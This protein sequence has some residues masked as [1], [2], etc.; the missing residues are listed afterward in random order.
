MPIFDFASNIGTLGGG[1][2]GNIIF[3]G[4][5]SN[6]KPPAQQL[7]KKQKAVAPG[8]IE[9]RARCSPASAVFAE[10]DKREGMRCRTLWAGRVC[11]MLNPL[12]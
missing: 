6:P 7:K 8:M 2:G 11:Y 10:P 1:G 3:R 9:K 5:S 12:S 4:L